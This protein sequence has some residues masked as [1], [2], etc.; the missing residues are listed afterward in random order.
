VQRSGKKRRV[1]FTTSIII[2]IVLL[3]GGFAVWALLQFL[4]AWFPAWFDTLFKV[5]AGLG[6]LTTT[7][8]AL[9]ESWVGLKPE[10]FWLAGS[11]RDPIEI[12]GGFHT[13][14]NFW[15]AGW[16]TFPNAPA[17]DQPMILK[18]GDADRIAEES[19]PV[20]LDGQVFIKLTI[21]NGHAPFQVDI[22]DAFVYRKRAPIR[23]PEDVFVS[24]PFGGE[25]IV[26]YG[27]ADLTGKP[28][29]IAEDG[30]EIYPVTL[31]VNGESKRYLRLLPGER[32]TIEL[33][34]KVDEPGVYTVHPVFEIAF[35][36][37]T[38]RVSTKEPYRFLY[39][40]RYRGWSSVET[41]GKQDL[42]SRLNLDDDVAM[43]WTHQI[44][45][46]TQL[47]TVEL[48]ASASRITNTCT[49][50]PRWIAFESDMVGYGM[51][52]WLFAVQSDG[53]HVKQIDDG[54]LTSDA[55]NRRLRW[56]EE[57][58]LVV[59]KLNE[60]K[61]WH[62][63]IP[64]AIFD[65]ESRQSLGVITTTFPI[66][67]TLHPWASICLR[68][69]VGC[70]ATEK[71]DANG[72]GESDRLGTLQ[73]HL[74][75]GVTKRRL[76]FSPG[77]D[78]GYLS[79]SPDEKWIAFVQGTGLVDECELG[80]SQRVWVMR[81]NG[82]EVRPVVNKPGCYRHVAWSSDGR[83]IAYSAARPPG[84]KTYH[85]YVTELE[86]GSEIQLT[87]GPVSDDWPRW[88]D[89]GEWVVAGGHRLTLSRADGSCTQEVLVAPDGEISNVTMQP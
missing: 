79:L 18:R 50:M 62:E 6:A 48:P 63:P 55:L 39:P 22:R 3:V 19:I 89:D 31:L 17:P 14:D 30:S 12:S 10:S 37:K 35:R 66:A 34:L 27:K 36:D 33:E 13:V 38:R 86:T 20:T 45:V 16:S 49:M 26:Y 88:S 7:V 64:G 59:A 23:D 85:I 2:G 1:F 53:N 56:T 68:G 76:G 69:D 80:Y 74:V 4:P 11:W 15:P 47:G 5:L 44:I 72:K 46:D 43:Y 87:D 52:T 65:P 70:L 25:G 51:S 54:G 60:S 28:S 81:V 84:E 77:E 57:G 40:K 78:Q 21:E 9:I 29:K 67:A 41:R 83:S 24:I 75:H 61:P 8:T 58:M 73:I 32:E 82:S 71:Y 42:R